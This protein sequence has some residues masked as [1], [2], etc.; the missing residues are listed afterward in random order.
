MPELF[1]QQIYINLE[2]QTKTIVLC[3]LFACVASL[4]GIYQTLLK[5]LQ[6]GWIFKRSRDSFFV[7]QLFIDCDDNISVYV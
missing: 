4:P 2:T 1:S 7:I 5:R 6:Q 3:R